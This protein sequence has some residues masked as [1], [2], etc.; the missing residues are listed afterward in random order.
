LEFQGTPLSG[1]HA[2]GNDLHDTRRKCITDNAKQ[3]WAWWQ[4]L[5]RQFRDVF[6]LGGCRHQISRSNNSMAHLRRLQTLLD[7]IGE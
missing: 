2:V 6:T 1:H 4:S 5:L 3:L 7:E